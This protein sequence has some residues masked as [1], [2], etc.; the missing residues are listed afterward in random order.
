[1]ITIKELA[2]ILDLS[3]TTVS[4][5]I[6]GKTKEVSKATIE[7]VQEALNTY[8]YVPNISASNLARNKSKIIGVALLARPDKCVALLARPDKYPNLL[9]DPF[10]S[11]LVSSLERTIRENGYFMMVYIADEIGGIIQQITSWNADGVVLFGLMGDTWKKVGERYKKPIVSVDC[12][13][14]TERENVVNIGLQDEEGAYLAA[15]HLIEN[16]HR[17]IAFLSDNIHGVDGER[18]RGFRRALEEEGLT[19]CDEDF[20]QLLLSEKSAE[21]CFRDLAVRCEGYTAFFCV[22][23]LYAV[24][25][26]NALR[27]LGKS[28]PED[29]SIVGFDDNM[30]SWFY[31]PAITTIHQ[32]TEMK[33]VLAGNILVQMIEGRYDGE[34]KVTLPVSLVERDTVKK[35]SR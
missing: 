31:R 22:S 14:V 20:L 21:E 16:G 5:V 1:M 7:R 12:F 10:I 29:L 35:I 11:E 28:I 27:A 2:E 23:D 8:N 34:K 17:R 26:A 18:F 3:T 33:G 24:Q 6:H 19:F 32:D 15:R 13:D 30:L 4:N 25:L 9:T